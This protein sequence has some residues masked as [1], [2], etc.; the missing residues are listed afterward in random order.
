MIKSSTRSVDSYYRKMFFHQSKQIS[1]TQLTMD[2]ENFHLLCISSL[3]TG[4]NFHFHLKF[5]DAS[6]KK[7]R[8]MIKILIYKFIEKS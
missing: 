3:K 5:E 4:L 1:R 2:C 6:G 8:F 7:S